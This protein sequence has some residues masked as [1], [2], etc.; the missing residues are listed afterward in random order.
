MAEPLQSNARYEQLIDQLAGALQPVRPLWPVWAKLVVLTLIEV[1]LFCIF[2]VFTGSDWSVAARRSAGLMSGPAVL[3]AAGLGAGWL[4][5]RSS[6]PGRGPRLVEV[7][8][9]VVVALT[10]IIL[11]IEASARSNSLSGDCAGIC[12][13]GELLALTCAPWLLMLCWAREGV[14]LNPR[15]T[16]ALAGASA[17]LFALATLTILRL[18]E[19]NSLIFWGVLPALIV[20]GAS[21]LI[22]GALLRNCVAWAEQRQRYTRL[23]ESV[24]GSEAV[25]LGRGRLTHNVGFRWPMII[26]PAA[27]ITLL[28]FVLVPR[29]YRSPE[30]AG[31]VLDFD[32]AIAAYQQASNGFQPNVPSASVDTIASAYIDHGIPPYVWDFG[33]EGYHLIGGRV[34]S[35]PEG[36]PAAFTLYRRGENSSIICMIAQTHRLHPPPGM[37]TEQHHYRFYNY[38]G[39]RI[40]ICYYGVYAAVMVSRIPMEEFVRQVAAVVPQS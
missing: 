35:T 6:V 20:P 22:G 24:E 18:G 26:V 9:C 19:R 28:V 39:Y 40:G 31:K 1:A 27:A 10:G 21:A 32:I 5:F 30:F 4:S 12:F 25:T 38:R 7:A 13:L 2:A 29:H 36:N 8:L 3:F 34:G 15:L 37:Y 33:R 23:R 17:G 11:V 14:P 16:A